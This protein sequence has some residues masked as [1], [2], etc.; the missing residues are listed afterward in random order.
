MQITS[1]NEFVIIIM[2]P[3]KYDI[4]F[5]VLVGTRE[6]SCHSLWDN[7]SANKLDS[8]IVGHLMQVFWDLYIP[9]EKMFKD[10]P[11][12]NMLGQRK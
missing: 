1:Y 7:G 9:F 6:L 4:Q 2:K 12:G 5:Y 8:T 11:N 3:I 10:N